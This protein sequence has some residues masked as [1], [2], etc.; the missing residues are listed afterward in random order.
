MSVEDQELLARPEAVAIRI[1]RAER[2]RG[3]RERTRLLGREL[4]V[5]IRVRAREERSGS[6]EGSFLRARILRSRL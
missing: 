4:P 6:S 2:L 1:L 3:D 5:V